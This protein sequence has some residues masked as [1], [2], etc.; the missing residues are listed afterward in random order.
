LDL[1]VAAGFDGSAALSGRAGGEHGCMMVGWH[2]V[3]APT[4]EPASNIAAAVQIVR[5]R[6]VVVVRHRLVMRAGD[7]G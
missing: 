3:C 7:H 2:D 4:L 5:E 1:S 6:K